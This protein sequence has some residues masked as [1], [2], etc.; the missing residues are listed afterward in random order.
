ME[1]KKLRRLD[2]IQTAFN[3]EKIKNNNSLLKNE[4]T[5]F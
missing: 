4:K 5:F 3:F 1:R 2:G